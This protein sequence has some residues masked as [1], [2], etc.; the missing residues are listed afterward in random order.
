MFEEKDLGV[1]IDSE[2]SFSEHVAS[3]VRTA[4][5]IV[6]LI[7]RSCSFLD[8]T[9]FK[10]LSTAFVRPHLEYAQSVWSP[11]LRKHINMLENVQ[12]RATKLVDG[13][14]RLDYPDR[15]KILNLPTLAYRRLRGDLIEIYKHFHHYDIETIV[16]PGS[17]HFSF[18]NAMPKMVHEESNQTRFTIDQQEHGITYPRRWLTQNPSIPSRID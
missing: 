5:A 13:L 10:K 15:L 6:G 7:R 17:M 9:S 12:I 4:N 16:S 11:H 3:K 8:G 2:L 14:A 1:I 18:S